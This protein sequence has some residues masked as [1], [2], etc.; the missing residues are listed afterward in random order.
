VVEPS[1]ISTIR[2]WPYAPMNGRSVSLSPIR[3]TISSCAWPLRSLNEAHPAT[4]ST[5]VSLH[6]NNA[7][8]LAFVILV[9]IPVTIPVLGF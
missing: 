7:D 2:L 3:R 8:L 5:S 4:I 6:R 9:P 1:T